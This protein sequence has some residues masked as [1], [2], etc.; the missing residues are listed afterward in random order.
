M[1]NIEKAK[2]T[3]IDQL[4]LENDKLLLTNTKLKRIKSDLEIR[5]NKEKL[6][7]LYLII[8]CIKNN[9]NL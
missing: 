4:K 7:N 3:E 9:V 8:Y 6:K 5:N 2:T 1:N